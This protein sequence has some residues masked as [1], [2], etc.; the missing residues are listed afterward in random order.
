MKKIKVLLLVLLL[1][2]VL[3]VSVFGANFSGLP[4][5]SLHIANGNLG[6]SFNLPYNSSTLTTVIPGVSYWTL[7]GVGVV[8]EVL[9]PGYWDYT[10]EP[11]VWVNTTY[12]GD[13]TYSG[14]TV[15]GLIIRESHSISVDL[16]IP[17]YVWA[18]ILDD[19]GGNDVI[20]SGG[21][22]YGLNTNLSSSN[23]VYAE[24]DFNSVNGPITMTG[25]L[26][27]DSG[28]A[29]VTGNA[30]YDLVVNGGTIDVYG[31]FESIT[32]NGG[33]VNTHSI[34]VNNINTGD[35][36]D[37][38]IKLNAGTLNLAG[39]NNIS[40]YDYGLWVHDG[41]V[42][43]ALTGS[44][45]ING[46]LNN[47]VY[48]EG[49]TIYLH[50]Y[51]V[52]TTTSTA[53]PVAISGSASLRIDAT[54]TV[55][56]GIGTVIGSGTQ[57]TL[58]VDNGTRVIRVE[59]AYYI[60]NGTVTTG[61]NLRVY[62]TSNASAKVVGDGAGHAL[63]VD[64]GIVTISGSLG[65][66]TVNGGTVTAVGG[67]IY[68]DVN[69]IAGTMTV[70][71]ADL[72][73]GE[74]GVAGTVGAS[75]TFI[76][77]SGRVYIPFTNDGDYKVNG[78]TVTGNITNTS[79]GDIYIDGGTVWGN[80]T[81]NGGDIYITGGTYSGTIYSTSGN[82]YV[83]AS[84]AGAPVKVYGTYTNIAGPVTM[85]GSNLVINGTTNSVPE[86]YTTSAA[87]VTG[88]SSYTLTV[89]AGDVTLNGS[90][91]SA[92]VTG[93]KLTDNGGNSVTAR[94][95]TVVGNTNLSSSSTD[96]RVDN[97]TEVNSSV[98]AYGNFHTII[99]DSGDILNLTA[100]TATSGSFTN[101][102]TLNITAAHSANSGIANSGTIYVKTDGTITGTVTSTTGNLYVTSGTAVDVSGTFSNIAGN[103]HMTN[104]D[105]TLSG[106]TD[107]LGTF[108]ESKAIVAG[109]A[110]HFR[111]LGG[112]VTLNG[113]VTD[114][115]LSGGKLTD[116]GGNTVYGYHGILLGNG[117]STFTTL[118]VDN[119]N[120][121]DSSIDASGNYANIYVSTRDTL[122]LSGGAVTVSG[123]EI[124]NAGTL[125]VYSATSVIGGISN[126]GTIDVKTDGSIVGLITSTTGNL[127]VRSGTAVDVKGTFSNIAG[128]VA[129]TGGAL[130]I[131][132]TADSNG[133][134]GSS[135]AI[136][137]GAAFT[138]I[139]SGSNS[140][141]TLNGSV[142]SVAITGGTLTDNGGNT[143]NANASPS[144]IHVHGI[145]TSLNA[146][147]AAITY[148]KGTFVLV[149]GAITN[150]DDLTITYAGIN[151]ATPTY[152]A[153]TGSSFDHM[154]PDQR[155]DV[156]YD[157]IVQGGYT[158]INSTF[159]TITN[160]AIM[161][162]NGLTTASAISNNNGFTVNNNFTLS[163]V[164]LVNS[165]IGEVAI[166][167]TLVGNI[168]NNSTSTDTA[169]WVDG[170]LNGTL[171]TN[172]GT[173]EIDGNTLTT[174]I[175]NG[176]TAYIS[177]TFHSLVGSAT[178]S[179]AIRYGSLAYSY[180]TVTIEG[181]S[182]GKATITGAER[183]IFAKGSYDY[184]ALE[185]QAGTVDIIGGKISWLMVTGGN[186]AIKGGT[187]TAGYL[188]RN[189][190]I[191]TQVPAEVVVNV[192]S[193]GTLEVTGGLFYD[194]S[195]VPYIKAGYTYSE[196][197]TYDTN[198]TYYQVSPVIYYYTIY[199]TPIPVIPPTL[200]F[201]I[202][203][204]D[205][206]QTSGSAIEVV[207]P[208]DIAPLLYENRTLLPIRFVVEPLGGSITW[209][210]AEQKVTI[211]RG[212]TTIE[213]WIGNNMAKIN[214]VAVMIDPENPN[215]KPL[216][217]DPGRTMLPL[218]FISEALGCIVT[219]DDVKQ[220]VIITY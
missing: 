153:I 63:I 84:Y 146:T 1:I 57:A 103:V 195:M 116:N 60:L 81:N 150:C 143:V 109:A 59:G 52:T 10:P 147:G 132:G 72:I 196:N 88:N 148:A 215:V 107:S 149:T 175:V 218:R 39:V 208:M 185:V 62:S 134:Y 37:Y 173:V 164:T 194:T 5:G 83:S 189:T 138:L 25:D 117:S 122:N 202:G 123:G 4:T 135:K 214:G 69:I 54:T 171:T 75:G 124:S 158:Y 15:T 100:A 34:T 186:V 170:A 18:G 12:T 182:E 206:F 99:V 142:A 65:M 89:N 102:G 104:A 154:G 56:G 29:S 201:N 9:V 110:A 77:N 127:Y 144:A 209:N 50:D 220:E 22:V 198:H 155:V 114:A 203:E 45:S 106:T 200:R 48:A 172:A 130:T 191:N 211:I 165:G 95:G 187:F 7:T 79:I 19:N 112:D 44:G 30:N 53:Y 55:S 207:R 174:L 141:V 145:G 8:A 82:L 13:Y 115:D 197:N 180:S 61:N 2:G 70:E 160:A 128:N 216:I 17:V 24:G 6:T 74:D 33:T 66:V 26:T 167:G 133:T 101:N 162:V 204:K 113:S 28:T 49:G 92:L 152:A 43:S 136:V 94:G 151:G 129:M 140:D 16:G 120:E 98:I 184:P 119:G 3:A 188:V 40:A 31:S 32:I 91:L 205:S 46:Y 36:T 213:L 78:G 212:T 21:T 38:G 217:I 156:F 118:Y 159:A 157:L 168:T 58:I 93:G 219:W 161:E 20:A 87:I 137:T 166:A 11:D 192:T 121:H 177:G 42:T 193:P 111:M 108:G 210:P 23:T 178:I 176:G 51:D 105:L 76:V 86:T 96:L 131:N 125:N 71:G 14:G 73:V 90:V 126:S 68:N 47:G 179:D 183:I 97:N 27:I 85:S 139:I 199:V 190:D 35:E 169:I 67:S 41:N 163:S 64:T 80:I 181:T